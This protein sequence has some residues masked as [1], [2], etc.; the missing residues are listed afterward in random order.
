MAKTVRKK[1]KSDEQTGKLRIADHWNAIS[2]IASSQ[3]NPLKAVAEFVENSI[4]ARA[5]QVII[6]RGKKKGEFYPGTRATE[7]LKSRQASADRMNTG[8]NRKHFLNL[9]DRSSAC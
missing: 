3:A 9:P 4:D 7:K 5:R 1:R 8:T 2:I 6:M